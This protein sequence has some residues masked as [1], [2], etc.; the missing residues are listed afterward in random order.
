MLKR[1]EMKI[2]EEKRRRALENKL[3]AGDVARFLNSCKAI[4]KKKL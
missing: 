4:H 3:N 2:P 1:R